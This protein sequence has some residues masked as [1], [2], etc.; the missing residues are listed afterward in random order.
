MSFLRN[1]S[2]K[3]LSINKEVKALS[4]SEGDFPRISESS[5][6]VIFKGKIDL[7]AF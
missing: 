7:I 6:D 2:E 1:Y 5:L 4:F 3:S